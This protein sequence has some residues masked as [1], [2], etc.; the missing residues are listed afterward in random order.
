[1][2]SVSEEDEIVTTSDEDIHSRRSSRQEEAV[3]GATSESKP[4]LAALATTT[5]TV[6]GRP[7]GSNKQDTPIVRAHYAHHNQQQLQPQ[8][9]QL[10]Q[11]SRRSRRSPEGRER[12]FPASVT[13]RAPLV[14][15]G[16]TMGAGDDRYFTTNG[17]RCSI[18]TGHF[19]LTFDDRND[20]GAGSHS[21]H[22]P[23]QQGRTSSGRSVRQMP[24]QVDGG[25]H[26][27]PQQ[28]Q[29]VYSASPRVSHGGGGSRSRV[30]S[31]SRE[32]YQSKPSPSFP[33]NRPNVGGSSTTI[34]NAAYRNPATMY[35]Q[36]YLDS[37][38]HPQ[39]RHLPQQDIPPP[40]QHMGHLQSQIMIGCDGT[41]LNYIPGTLGRQHRRSKQQQQAGIAVPKST[42][43]DYPFSTYAHA[44]LDYRDDSVI[45]RSMPPVPYN[46]YSSTMGNPKK[47]RNVH[48]KSGIPQDPI[49]S[50]YHQFPPPSHFPDEA[51]GGGPSYGFSQPPMSLSYMATR[52]TDR[53][54]DSMGQSD[55]ELFRTGET[56]ALLPREPPDGIENS[57][58]IKSQHHKMETMSR[59]NSKSD[60]LVSE[61]SVINNPR[62]SSSV[63]GGSSGSGLP[64]ASGGE[65]TSLGGGDNVSV[66]SAGSTLTMGG[67]GKEL[68]KRDSIPGGS[69]S[70]G[71]G[72]SSSGVFMDGSGGSSSVNSVSTTV[73]VQ[74]QQLGGGVNQDQDLDSVLATSEW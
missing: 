45:P 38:S 74:Q 60:L 5:T 58:P 17:Q 47:S 29:V 32:Y 33:T 68:L 4:Q 42:P 2:S 59:K 25:Q 7:T 11:R 48:R 69:S 61:S 55:E 15:T 52:S 8:Q 12:E 10:S 9:Q 70:T 50:S 31:G 22:V 19:H 35:A 46:N 51:S 16:T 65:E 72:V 62:A 24:Q 57:E 36:D 54:L 1:M 37:Y 43:E 3:A 56:L 27:Q 63:G 28:Q 21:G 23:R 14:V 20:S 64:S 40:Q 34:R 67:A 41:T 6:K 30:R 66:L 53:N 26:H 44:P 13:G 49:E 18:G 71:G 73:T 39:Q